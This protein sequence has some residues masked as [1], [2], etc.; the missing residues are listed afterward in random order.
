M[1]ERKV[2]ISHHKMQ[3]M[4]RQQIIDSMKEELKAFESVASKNPAEYITCFGLTQLIYNEEKI[5]KSMVDVLKQLEAK[6]W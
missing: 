3:M 5:Y 1:D 2:I 6:E 4:L